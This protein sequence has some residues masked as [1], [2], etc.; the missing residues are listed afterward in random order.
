MKSFHEQLR[1]ELLELRNELDKVKST[2]PILF[3]KVYHKLDIVL[4]DLNRYDNKI[5]EEVHELLKK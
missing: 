5:K 3:Q 4:F 1:E 2:N